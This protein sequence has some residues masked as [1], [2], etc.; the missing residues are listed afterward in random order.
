MRF[1]TQQLVGA[2]VDQPFLPREVHRQVEPAKL[3]GVV[4]ARVGYP[5]A[6]QV[7]GCRTGTGAGSSS[8]SSAA[9]SA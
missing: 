4:S 2:G 6:L 7:D 1:V 3:R 9:A 8:C 5:E